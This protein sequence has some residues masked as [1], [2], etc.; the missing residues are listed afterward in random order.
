M[1]DPGPPP[2]SLS[3]HRAVRHLSD[4]AVPQVDV[5]AVRDRREDVRL[6]RVEGHVVDIPAV[7]IDQSLLSRR[8]CQGADAS[9][10]REGRT[11]IYARIWATGSIPQLHWIH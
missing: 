3:A 7:T 6:G 8:R 1:E 11:K 2:P 4:G 9:Q 5:A 10:R